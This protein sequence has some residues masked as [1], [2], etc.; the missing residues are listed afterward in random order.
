VGITRSVRYALAKFGIEVAL[1][2]LTHFIGPPLLTAAADWAPALHRSFMSAY[3]FD[4]PTARQAVEYYREYFAATGIYE[5]ELYPGIP[6]LL[7]GLQAAGLR[8][9]V[10]TSKPTFYAEQIVRHFGLSGFFDAVVGAEMDLT[11]T[12]K[13]VLVN[14]ALERYAGREASAAVMIGD[15]EY[16]VLGAQA[17][18]IDSIAVTYGAGSRQEL[19]AAGPTRIVDS[20]EELAAVLGL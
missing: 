2:S 15:R 10:V 7:G 3:A 20:I 6:G 9:C 17:N 13:P 14:R 8:L 18:G 1:E 4:E 11:N 5:N 19:A 12:E 16:D